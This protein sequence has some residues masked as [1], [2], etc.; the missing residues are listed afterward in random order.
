MEGDHEAGTSA[1]L[2]EVPAEPGEEEEEEDVVVVAVRLP[3][4]ERIAR[5][6]V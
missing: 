2:A 5:R 6:C 3:G 1:V 4:G